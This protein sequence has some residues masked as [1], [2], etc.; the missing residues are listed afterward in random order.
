VTNKSILVLEE[1]SVVHGLIASA[2]D[3]DGLT[4]HH[5]FNPAKYVDRAR[6]LKPD[7]IL[8]SNADQFNNYS[9]CRQLKTGASGAAPLVLLANSKDKLDDTR[10]RDLRVDGVVRKPFEASDLQE[11]V[12]RHLH[13]PDLV[14]AAYEYRQSQ[15]AREA[16][17]DPLAQM[18]VL[19]EETVAMMKSTGAPGGMPVP[20]VDFSAELRRESGAGDSAAQSAA[21]IHTTTTTRTEIRG[22]RS[23]S[24]AEHTVERLLEGAQ[25]PLPL[26][27]FDDRDLAP[28]GAAESEALL[29]ASTF[30]QEDLSEPFP[31]MRAGED[32]DFEELGVEDLLDDETLE[33]AGQLALDEE[34][35]ETR[36]EEPATLHPSPLD[37]IDVELSASDLLAQ[38]AASLE[39]EPD[40]MTL[41]EQEFDA[42]EK[43]RQLDENIPLAVRRMMEQKPVFTAP[44]RAM[45]E[46]LQSETTQT[47][48]AIETVRTETSV[49]AMPWPKPD[50]EGPGAD[51]PLD[52]LHDIDLGEDEL[53]EEQIL[54]AMES[55]PMAEIDDMEGLDDDSLLSLSLDEEDQLTSLP[56][57]SESEMEFSAPE[58]D[59]EEI[60]IDEDEEE[61][62]LSSLEEEEL[63]DLALQTPR[64]ASLDLTRTERA[65]LDEIMS[66]QDSTPIPTLSSADSQEFE[67]MDLEMPAQEATPRETDL[68]F[69]AD[70]FL[71]VP[72]VAEDF[73]METTRTTEST[74]TTTT[75]TVTTQPVQT[76]ELQEAP[77]IAIE[78]GADDLE[79]D[80]F[81]ETDLGTLGDDLADASGAKEA[82]FF[83]ELTPGPLPVLKSELMDDL[84]SDISLDA[85]FLPPLETEP[86]A[87]MESETILEPEPEPFPEPEARSA[88]ST[89]GGDE[90]L[91]FESAFA[92]LRDEIQTN[93]E[94]EH[95]DDVLRLEGIQNKVSRLDF[96]I[97]QHE[98]PFAR[99]I[100]LYAMANG[101]AAA[102]PAGPAVSAARVEA[103]QGAQQARQETRTVTTGQK[104]RTT[105]IETQLTE[106]LEGAPLTRSL[107]DEPTKARLS[108]VLDE[109]IS[110]SVRKAVREEMPRL[111]QRL[112]K[113]SPQA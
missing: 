87:E 71:E 74:V 43:F 102:L 65:G 82:D 3:V 81:S 39:P 107:L 111:M 75:Q 90:D 105:T 55:E 103:S 86:M 84:A 56:E 44:P 112:A 19:D 17:F 37:K 63:E 101:G 38:Q 26:A 97:P 93:P 69:P 12:S 14:G 72:P 2:L 48:T 94:G 46:T 51:T 30:E 52:D 98:S 100:G 4:L 108:Q 47:R 109:I 16:M 59:D 11:Q 31:S 40:D 106:A 110:I 70:E 23:E 45:P 89:P 20:E 24:R 35:T 60:S 8:V 64:A 41:F 28:L 49:P 76:A 53:D 42:S 50:T 73:Q 85:E 78:F 10:L 22:S 62:I 96:T 36:I 6:S 15:S 29:E 99:G 34:I 66:V 104:V 88:E 67:A 57:P 32:A 21:A 83:P 77:D 9:I 13:M 58:E 92:A 1:N 68:P 5:E 7:L 80:L 33:E 79:A 95:L 54:S 113:D 61:L 27:D 91:E 18:E 25:S